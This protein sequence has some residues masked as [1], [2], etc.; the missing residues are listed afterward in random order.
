MVFRPKQRTRYHRPDAPP[1]PNEPPPPENPPPPPP[2]PPPPKPPPPQ[3]RPIGIGTIQG[4]PPLRYPRRLRLERKARNSHRPTIKAIQIRPCI[5]WGL[6]VP[7][8]R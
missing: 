2:Q 5:S 7:R 3:P 1:P 6:I 8:S 4:I